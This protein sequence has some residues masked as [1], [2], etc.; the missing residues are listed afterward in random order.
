MRYHILATDYDGTIAL[1]GKVNKQTVEALKQLKASARKLILV[2]GRELEEL[3]ALFPEYTLFDVIVAENGALIYDP[4]TMKEQLLG[5]RPPA[6][7]IDALKQQNVQP[8]S[9]GRVIVATWEPHETTVLEAIKS[10]G[11]EHQVIFNKGAVMVLPPGIN[12]AAGLQAVLKHMKY[13]SHNIVA[14]GDAENDIAMMQLAECSVAVA[15]A[16][17]S[18][19]QQ[20]SFVTHADH[21]AGVEELIAQLLENDFTEAD[22]YLERHYLQ[23][24]KDKFDKDYKIS[25]YHDGI[26]L[27]GSSGGGKSTLTTAFLENLIASNYQFCLVD[28][29]GDYLDFPDTVIVGDAEHEP[30]TEEIVGLLENPEQNVIVCLLAVPL[31]KRPS[32][33]NQLLSPIIDLRNKKGHPHWLVFDEVNHLLPPETEVTF[34]NIPGNLNNFLIITT[35][36]ARINDAI[37]KYANTLIVVGDKPQEMLQQYASLKSLSFDTSRVPKLD[38]GEALIWEAANQKEP[39]IISY[40]SPKQLTKRHIKKYATGKMEYNNFYFKGPAGKLNLKAYNVVVFMQLA[41]GV[42]DDTWM[43]HLKQNDYSKWFSDALHDD[44]LATLTKQIEDSSNDAKKSKE[45]ILKLIT[46]RYTV[47]G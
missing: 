32:F 43:F 27:T 18:V 47:Q 38:Q 7:F 20:V 15:N 16:L 34:F 17:Q 13:S 8:L 35:E 46:E 33:F 9:V 42:D 3:I 10:T 28:P 12:K 14:V 2:T 39:V 23:L 31:D 21:G 25:P 37:M 4:L 44:E 22:K 26:L 11:I 1:H 6:A 40:S 41:E 5:E 45:E 19:K 36:P 29:E 24:G 30:V